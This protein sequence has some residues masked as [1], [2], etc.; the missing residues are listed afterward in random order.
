MI[1]DLEV[2]RKMIPKLDIKVVMSEHLH[3][4]SQET[5]GRLLE[6]CEELEH[7]F[8]D[9]SRHFEF[10][11]KRLSEEQSRV[12]IPTITG[13]RKRPSQNL[14]T[15]G[16]KLAD[17]LH[18][19][20]GAF[21]FF[22][23]SKDVETTEEKI[24]T[25]ENNFLSD[26]VHRL[27][28]L[29]HRIGP[30][31]INEELDFQSGINHTTLLI[32]SPILQILNSMQKHNLIIQEDLDSFFKV[33]KTMEIIALNL[34]SDCLSEYMPYTYQPRDYIFDGGMNNPKYKELMAVIKA[35]QKR[36]LNYLFLK[37]KFM[38]LDSIIDDLEKKTKGAS[39]NDK[40]AYIE[41][42]AIKWVK[43]NVKNLRDLIFGE[44]QLFKNLEDYFMR[45]SHY[46]NQENTDILIQSSE[47]QELRR[48]LYHMWHISFE[49]LN[50][51]PSEAGKLAAKNS[52]L[53]VDF[54]VQTY[55][56]ELIPQIFYGFGPA[57]HPNQLESMFQSSKLLKD[58]YK[59]KI[60][61]QSLFPS[62]DNPLPEIDE[63]KL[64][65]NEQKKLEILKTLLHDAFGNG[66]HNAH[67]FNDDYTFNN[68]HA[69]QID[70]NHLI[71]E[72][73]KEVMAEYFGNV[74]DDQHYRLDQLT[75]HKLEYIRKTQDYSP[76]GSD[77]LEKL[78]LI[79]GDKEFTHKLDNFNAYKNSKY[80]WYSY[81]D[82]F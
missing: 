43:R 30:F 65:S 78:K 24:D 63:I 16:I 12:S 53:M 5:Y 13:K 25:S 45:K 31:N 69:F 4:D 35:K 14:K 15:D 67:Y 77:W 52:F 60:D 42:Q 79:L 8:G 27:N 1:K 11:Y 37:T 70:I 64:I 22:G 68:H 18:Q 36:E 74:L 62:G 46:S 82:F 21:R 58:L 39:K 44:S 9:L 33:E 3:K 29:L 10:E 72:N 75:M 17:I 57:K 34:F 47:F 49:I 76:Y 61:L 23:D 66:I 54:V 40:Q 7:I 73:W 80:E 19:E 51:D 48:K 28:S 59:Y 2:L 32:Q 41:I 55:G 38:N 20:S 50:S 6:G 56:K 71:D 26:V 81:S